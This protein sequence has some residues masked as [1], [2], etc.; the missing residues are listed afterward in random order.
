MRTDADWLVLPPIST[1]GL[2]AADVDDLTTS[3]RDTMLKTLVEMSTK[4]RSALDS[5]N[6]MATAVEI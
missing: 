3:T 4:N 5:G 2:T 1:K 6:A